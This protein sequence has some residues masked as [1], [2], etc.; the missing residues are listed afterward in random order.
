[1]RHAPAVTLS[2]VIPV[3]T[4][5]VVLSTGAPPRPHADPVPGR[6]VVSVD[7]GHSFRALP[8]AT[9]RLIVES[10]LAD[11]L[12]LTLA[13]LDS[14][15]EPDTPCQPAQAAQPDSAAA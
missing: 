14:L 7:L 3:Q 10:R 1:M 11:A 12:E 15:T 5:K 6:L 13:K 8:L 4:T 9:Q 2:E